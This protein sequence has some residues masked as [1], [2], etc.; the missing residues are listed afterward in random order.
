MSF[1]P[2]QDGRRPVCKTTQ[3]LA[4]ER[5]PRASLA[6]PAVSRRHNKESSRHRKRER[7]ALRFSLGGKRT[8]RKCTKDIY[9]KSKRG[10]K[11][12]DARRKEEEKRRRIDGK[13]GGGGTT[14]TKRNNTTD[15]PCLHVV[16]NDSNQRRDATKMDEWRP[17]DWGV[18][19]TL[20]CNTIICLI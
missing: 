11:E 8:E 14:T 15:R 3:V 16:M 6:R 9:F 17:F 20:G 5:R 13:D 12:N 19:S 18:D 7:G 4:R 10:A 1:H 2:S